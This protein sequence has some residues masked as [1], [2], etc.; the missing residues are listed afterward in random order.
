[1]SIILEKFKEVLFSV[2]PITALVIVINLFAGVLAPIQLAHFLIG[3]AFIV[4]GLAIF[5]LGVDIGIS[6]LAGHIGS[7]ISKRNSV[8][9]VIIVGF[10]L[11]FFISIAEPDL[12]ILASQVAAVTSGAIGNMEILLVVSVGIGACL[13]LGFLRIMYNYPLYKMLTIAYLIIF[14]LSLFVSPEFLAISFDSS[15]A[16]TGALTVPFVLALTLGVSALKRDSKASEKDSFGLVAIT[17]S[18]AIIGVMLLGVFKKLS[19]LSGVLPESEEAIS[20]VIRPF[21]VHLPESFKESFLAISPIA[22][23]YV[24]YNFFDLHLS[25]RAF[26]KILK[27]IVYSLIGLSV[28]LTGVNQGFMSVGAELGQWAAGLD[29]KAY[30]IFL[31]FV[32][33]LLTI[34]AEPAVHVLTS[35]IETVTSGYVKKNLVLA[36][37]AIGVG[38]AVALSVTRIVVP[39]IQ[40]WHYLLP[41][42]II[43]IVLAYLTP[44]LFVGIAFDS[45][46]VASGPMTATF[47]LA[48]SQGVADSVSSANVLTDAFGMIALVAMTPIIL[49]EMLGLV[50]KFKSANASK[51][52]ALEKAERDRA[53]REREA[54]EKASKERDAILA[55]QM[56]GAVD[57]G[58][59]VAEAVSARTKAALDMKFDQDDDDDDSILPV[60]G[61]PSSDLYENKASEIESRDP[62]SREL[63]SSDDEINNSEANLESSAS[64]AR[65]STL[66]IHEYTEDEPLD[67]FTKEIPELDIAES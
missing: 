2:V 7:S 38:L 11:G 61:I 19:G 30:A 36:T 10:V 55:L 32:L 16:T 6:P 22:V 14:A 15:G 65:E 64:A 62:E 33:G 24:I 18:G 21:M 40:L 60:E 4:I 57:A 59:E 20:G 42:Y 44:K 56:A 28:F 3:A 67:D 5:L 46:G 29:H 43:S 66:T 12:Q 26:S 49:L 31:G 58:A 25:R 17:S 1:M 27:G 63:E 54:L 47:V 37:L 51:L 53:A 23:I 52:A 41:G 48:F 34:L 39:Q 13:V 45:G 35:Q 8:V 50:F 9:L